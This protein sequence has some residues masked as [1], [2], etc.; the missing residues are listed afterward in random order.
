MAEALDERRQRLRKVLR[1]Y[2]LRLLRCTLAP[3][4]SQSPPSSD[5]CSPNN[6][7]DINKLLLMINELLNLIED[8]NYL[9]A[10]S[11]HAA[12]LVTQLPALSESS[13][14]EQVYSELLEHVGRFIMNS[15]D[16]E[17]ACRVI[18]VLCVAI[19]AFFYFTQ[20]NITGFVLLFS[21]PIVFF[22][23]N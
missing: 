16:Y 14:A 5:I 22:S 15:D 20:N 18:L 13:S 12:K 3:A 11:S 8:G 21:F 6:D 2:E 19:A 1:G 9:R 10:L 17:A 4:S 23:F 7:N